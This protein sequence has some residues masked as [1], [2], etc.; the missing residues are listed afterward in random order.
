MPSVNTARLTTVR[1]SNR[2]K[3]ITVNCVRSSPL[4]TC[5]Q[6]SR[7]GIEIDLYQYGASAKRFSQAKARAWGSLL[8]LIFDIVEP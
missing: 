1:T 4:K 8:V 2:Q 6:R 5:L 3:S 7:D